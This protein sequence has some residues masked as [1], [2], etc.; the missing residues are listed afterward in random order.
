MT[1]R[2]WM[3]TMIARADGD[4]LRA[5]VQAG[6]TTR[7]AVGRALNGAAGSCVC[8]PAPTV[9]VKPTLV[10]IGGTRCGARPTHGDSGPFVR[11]LPCHLAVGH[12]LDRATRAH[13]HTAV[14][15]IAPETPHTLALRDEWSARL[16]AA[17]VHRNACEACDWLGLRTCDEG[18]RLDDAERSAFGAYYT[19]RYAD[20]VVLDEV[21]R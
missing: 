10:E 2:H 12:E 1:G 9:E 17:T 6:H 13:A 21:R 14:A 7:C 11:L 20:P 5:A 4:A 8:P 19:A 18:L 16:E 15:R 3:P